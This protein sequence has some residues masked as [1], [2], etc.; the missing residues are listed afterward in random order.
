LGLLTRQGRNP[1]TGGT[2][3]IPASR[4]LAF[5]AA[6]SVR[7]ALNAGEPANTPVAEASRPRA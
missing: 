3:E 2:I 5:T 7:D 4:K 6:A 1:A